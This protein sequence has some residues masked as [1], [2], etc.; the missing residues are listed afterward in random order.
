MD[1]IAIV[2]SGVFGTITQTIDDRCAI[3]LICVRQ[4]ATRIV[5]RAT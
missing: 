2:H 5:A 1:Q 4:F 3:P